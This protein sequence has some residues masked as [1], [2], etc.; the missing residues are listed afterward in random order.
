MNIKNTAKLRIFLRKLL[1]SLFDTKGAILT[2]QYF[3]VMEPM[4]RNNG[5]L[6]TVKYF[7]DA[8]LAVTRFMCGKPLKRSS[9]RVA[10]DPS[11]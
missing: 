2:N 1:A 9:S 3:S 5:T 10:L 11:G 4:L 7:K 8:R 6:Y